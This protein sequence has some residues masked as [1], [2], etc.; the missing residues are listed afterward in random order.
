MQ[1]TLSFLAGALT[2]ALV[3]ATLAVLFAPTPGKELRQDI[4]DRFQALRTE[5]QDAAAGRRAEM[6]AQLAQLRAP[7]Q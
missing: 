2:G 3:G 4:T 7:R 5:M 6:E 1:K